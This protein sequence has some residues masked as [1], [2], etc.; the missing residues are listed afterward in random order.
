[1]PN[2]MDSC[3]SPRGDSSNQ[4]FVIHHVRIGIRRALGSLPLT[5]LSHPPRESQRY[6]CFEVLLCD[7]Y[8][9]PCFSYHLV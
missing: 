8:I 9:Y 5:T 6:Y 3:G 7:C 2:P 1:M 4:A